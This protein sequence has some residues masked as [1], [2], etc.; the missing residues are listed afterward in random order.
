[1]TGGLINIVSYGADDLY[2]TGAPQITFFKIMYRRYTNFSKESIYI[3]GGGFEFGKEIT[4]NV[5]KNGDL[6]SNTYLS[7]NIPEVLIKKVNTI[8]E[9]PQSYIEPVV[10][11]SSEPVF[12][13]NNI[14]NS[15]ALSKS[16]TAWQTSVE[17]S[18]YN[19]I[20]GFITN[21]NIIIYKAAKQYYAQNISA[22]TYVSNLLS[23]C[24]PS[25]N[26]SSPPI[27]YTQYNTILNNDLT[28]FIQQNPI[29]NDSY[30]TTYG[31]LC[32]SNSNLIDILF[33]YYNQ[34]TPTYTTQI[35]FDALTSGIRYSQ[36]VHDYYY[37]QSVNVQKN[38]IDIY[39]P[40]AK[41]AWVERLGHALI[42]K[43]DVMIGG[44]RMDRHYGDW[45]EIWHELTSSDGQQLCYKKMIGDVV[46]MKTYDRNAKPQYTLT[47]PLLFWF[48]QNIGLAFPLISLQ[49]ANISFVIK[50]KKLE[51]CAYIENVPQL[52]GL[53]NFQGIDYSVSLQDVWDNSGLTISG[54]ILIDYVYLDSHE[55]KR[56]AQSAH[57]YLTQ[58][59]QNLTIPNIDTNAS[60]QSILLDFS[61]PIKELIWT[62]R[63]NDYILGTGYH[64]SNWFNYGLNS[65]GSVNPTYSANMTFNG[66]IRFDMSRVQNQSYINGFNSST[67]PQTQT[68]GLNQYGWNNS[69]PVSYNSGNL[70]SSDD[71]TTSIYYTSP[72]MSYFNY[73]Q[74]YAYHHRTPK[75]GINVYSFALF[76]EE[77]QPSCVCNFSRIANSMFN[78]TLNPAIFTYKLDSILKDP[79]VY[80]DENSST[81]HIITDSISLNYQFIQYALSGAT[82]TSSNAD[83]EAVGNYISKYNFT[84]TTEINIYAVGYNILRII[85][86]M[87]A[88]A[89]Y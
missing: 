14:S 80:Y 50:L 38:Y 32:S 41:F 9:I 66:Y 24:I 44:E 30:S 23:I 64:K 61:G 87:A 67:P 76:P 18:E 22:T 56:F 70:I 57:E 58:T 31:I 17:Y 85:G 86:G 79:F 49:Y 54:G 71:I 19:K 36:M 20:I 78:L 62:A 3:D 39:S 13:I 81:P 51:H 7:I 26:L 72:S 33:F 88:Y 8:S 27:S 75:D 53:N 69:Q 34:T 25:L 21:Y 89:Y 16:A 5:P 77:H 60:Q 52:T 45:F 63:R 15:T 83:V 59:V 35:V 43:I 48:C 46:G 12:L 4:I 84:G 37:T 2:L 82:S 68:M 10:G 6:I 47:I 29:P 73:L 1:M 55:R 65:N 42:D 40:Y 74:P 28:T 11:S